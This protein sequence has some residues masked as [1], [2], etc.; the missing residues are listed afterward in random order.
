M[1]GR[2]PSEEVQGRAP[3]LDVDDSSR[4]DLPNRQPCPGSHPGNV[5]QKSS[6]GLSP[7]SKYPRVSLACAS[8]SQEVG[9]QDWVPESSHQT[10][11]DT[12][13]WGKHTCDIPAASHS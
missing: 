6:T 11:G 9:Q 13:S 2:K 12:P 10:L 8:T 4:H 3:G 7:K 1:R 5:S